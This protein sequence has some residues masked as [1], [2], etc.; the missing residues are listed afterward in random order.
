MPWAVS[1]EGFGDFLGFSA[2]DAFD[3]LPAVVGQTASKL[4]GLGY[5]SESLLR[6]LQHDVDGRDVT[7]CGQDLVPQKRFCQG[8]VTPRF[9]K[10]RIPALGIT[11]EVFDNEIVLGRVGVLEVADRIDT[12]RVRD[13]PGGLG[14]FLDGRQRLAIKGRAFLRFNNKEEIVV[15]RVGVLQF[16][17]GLQFGVGLREEHP[18]VGGKLEI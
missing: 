8:H 11:H 14:Q 16:F 10:T 5:F 12:N 6:V 7:V 13:L 15:L 3:V 18:V 4:D 1:S 17:E 9:E 2:A